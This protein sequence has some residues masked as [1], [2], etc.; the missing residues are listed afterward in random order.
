[1]PKGSFLLSRD[2]TLIYLWNLN[3]VNG[4]PKGISLGQLSRESCVSYN[5]LGKR[6]SYWCEEGFINKKINHE[7]FGRPAYVY[8]LGRRGKRFVG[9]MPQERF[10]AVVTEI[11]KRRLERRQPNG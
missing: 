7:S 5:Y 8:M 1:M 3:V 10:K 11:K 2:M 6:L 4:Y 9:D